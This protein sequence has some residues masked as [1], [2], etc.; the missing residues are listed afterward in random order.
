M[1]PHVPPGSDPQQIPSPTLSATISKRETSICGFASKFQEDRRTSA[2]DGLQ[3][4]RFLSQMKSEMQLP[5]S[6]QD[7]GPLF[8][9]MGRGKPSTTEPGQDWS[10]T[11]DPS[12]LPS[13]RMQRCHRALPARR[14]G[15]SVGSDCQDRTPERFWIPLGW[16]CRRLGGPRRSQPLY[17][18]PRSPSTRRR[19]TSP[20]RW[21]GACKA[22][23]KVASCNRIQDAV[24]LS[25][26]S[27]QLSRPEAKFLWGVA[28]HA[29]CTHLMKPTE[30]FGMLLVLPCTHTELVHSCLFP[31]QSVCH[32][33]TATHGRTD[34]L[35]QPNSIIVLAAIVERVGLAPS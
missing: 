10:Q 32:S 4:G 22:E 12:R 30:D 15:L 11:G 14:R 6:C 8:R 2:Q 21:P 34:C 23:V 1:H 28:K 27:K 35:S 13:R 9:K 18:A 16:G 26:C 20:G 33:S 25:F 19:W 7:Y 5:R 17:T 3:S 31:K 29:G 24:G